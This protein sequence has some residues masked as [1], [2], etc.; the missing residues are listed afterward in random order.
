MKKFSKG[1]CVILGITFSLIV[2]IMFCLSTKSFQGVDA[3]GYKLVQTY[4]Q[5]DIGN[6]TYMLVK[7][8]YNPDSEYAELTFVR[9]SENVEVY[10]PK[11]SGTFQVYR[12]AELPVQ[13]KAI[14]SDYIVFQIKNLPSTFKLGKLV[15]HENAKNMEGNG[16]ANTDAESDGIYFA[17]K[18]L[19]PTPKLKV[20]KTAFYEKESMDIR[21]HLIDRKLDQYQKSMQEL[22][23]ESSKLTVY[24][25]E[26]VQE[27][28]SLVGKDKDSTEEK[29][30][31]IISQIETLEVELSQKQKESETLQKQK[32][33]YKK[34]YKTK[35]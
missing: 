3:S 12:G 25:K 7:Q 11:I 32:A 9:K 24:Q 22:E 30:Q 34:Q 19:E 15:I 20:Q 17:K 27:K 26:L 21:I 13:T 18:N 29:I 4:T 33:A 5:Q 31:S 2:T 8:A 28:E 35:E 16:V 10:P 14:Q 23:K 6:A 1:Q